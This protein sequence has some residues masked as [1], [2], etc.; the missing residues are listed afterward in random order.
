MKRISMVEFRR[1]AWR[2]LNAVRRGER[3][4]LTY[5]GQPIARLEPVRAEAIEI[6]AD[7]PLLRIDDFAVEGPGSALR[8]EEMDRLVHGS[9]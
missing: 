2:A 9:G 7:D 5:R 6:P 8:N 1:N 3:F 4:L